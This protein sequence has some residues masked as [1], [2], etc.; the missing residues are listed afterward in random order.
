MTGSMRDN[1]LNLS[2]S[3]AGPAGRDG[4]TTA[5]ARSGDVLYREIKHCRICGNAN[6]TRVLDLS[7]QYLTG[8][9]PSLTSPQVGRGP[10][11]LV[12]CVGVARNVCGL[13][14]LRHNFAAGELYGETYGYRSG[15]NRSMVEHLHRKADA[16]QRLVPLRAGDLVLDI[17]SNDG[18]SL[19]RYPAD[20][21]T[22][23]GIDPSARKFARYYR[24][25]VRLIVD[26]FSA[27]LFRR[28]FG[29]RKARII[30]SIA[31]FYDLEEPQAFVDDVARILAD[32]GVWHLEQSYLPSMLQ[33]NAFDTVCHEHSEYY[34]LCQI[35]WMVR[36]A[37]LQ[38]IDVEL[39]ATNGGSFAVTVAR[40]QAGIGGNP[41]AV[42]RVLA[43]E[44][45]LGLDTLK[46]FEAFWKRVLRCREDLL[47]FFARAKREH[48]TIIGYGASTKGNVLLQFCGVTPDMM[49]CIAEVNDDK[50]GRFTPGTL[51]PIVSEQQARAMKPDYFLVLPWHFRDSIIEREA[52]YRASGGKLVFP[53]PTLEIVA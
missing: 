53:L 51:I 26:F 20:G 39:N 49:P 37:G 30:T 14:Q 1:S 19:G 25:G 16:L 35:D 15:L 48:K 13:V 12:K 52:A 18:T 40:P 33:A 38:I 11:E 44:A 5:R 21:P 10:I 23:V 28:H 41:S 31:M 7:E 45:A 47:E 29:D 34:A 2:F 6:L 50:F 3:S 46:P 4:S 22:L 27:D 32:D 8:V 36:R 9:F 17:G 24:P 43:E 42:A